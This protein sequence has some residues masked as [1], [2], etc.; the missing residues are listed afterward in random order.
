MKLTFVCV[1]TSLFVVYV[2]VVRFT[3][4]GAKKH[5]APPAS[6][7]RYVGVDFARGICGVSVIRSGESMETALR[8]CCQVRRGGWG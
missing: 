5:A 3:S 6:G 1:P 4:A 7:H 2:F 8:E